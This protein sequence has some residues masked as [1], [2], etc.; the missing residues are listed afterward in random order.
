MR[1]RTHANLT[2]NLLVALLAGGN[3]LSVISETE[4]VSWCDRYRSSCLTLELRPRR[5]KTGA[6]WTSITASGLRCGLGATC[7]AVETVP[8]VGRCIIG[9]LVQ[10]HCETA[11][12]TVRC[13]L[14]A[15]AERVGMTMRSLI[16][17][18]SMMCRYVY[19]TITMH[20]HRGK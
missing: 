15:S 4:A 2:P 12:A 19:R 20:P 16:S 8:S 5:K 7:D 3:R 18:T 17:Y 10:P 9:Q 14:N 13:R 6:D 1:F 11:S